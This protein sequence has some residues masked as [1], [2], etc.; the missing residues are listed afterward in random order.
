MPDSNYSNQKGK[1]LNYTEDGLLPTELGKFSLIRIKRDHN[2]L[3]KLRNFLYAKDDE[4]PL[5]KSAPERSD[6]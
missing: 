5:T 1:F 2:Y 6:F 3:N 4:L